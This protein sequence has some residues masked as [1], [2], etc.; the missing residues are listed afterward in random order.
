MLETVLNLAV[1]IKLLGERGD[2]FIN[3]SDNWFKLLI[4][5]KIAKDEEAI[6]AIAFEF[7]I[8]KHD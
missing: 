8:G 2:F 3:C 7:S 1:C 4:A 5:K 6:G